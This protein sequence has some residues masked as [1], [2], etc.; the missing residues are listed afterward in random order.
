M[1]QVLYENRCKCNEEV[2]LTKKQKLNN[3]SDG[4]PFLYPTQNEV[5]IKT[6]QIRYEKKL[7]KVAKLLLNSFQNK[8]LYYAVDDILYLLKSNL[9]EQDNLLNIVYSSVLALQNNLSINFFDIWIHE[10]Y[11][12]ETKTKNK[13][14]IQNTANSTS[15]SYITIKLLYRTKVPIKK[16]ESLW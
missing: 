5:T 14:L 11:I 16:Q 7:S 9:F 13:F 15:I 1:N 10:I 8:Y 4:K 2:S 12:N 6:F 3:R